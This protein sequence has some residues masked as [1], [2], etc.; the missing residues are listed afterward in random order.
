MVPTR[1]EF[2]E[3][4][5]DS[6]ISNALLFANADDGTLGSISQSVQMLELNRFAQGGQSN[7]RSE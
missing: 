1:V 2:E 5:Y 3:T 7:G 6:I 4:Y